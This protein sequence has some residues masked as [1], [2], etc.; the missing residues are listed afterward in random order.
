M[1]AIL[2]T[3]YYGTVFAFFCGKKNR[4]QNFDMRKAL[5]TRLRLILCGIL[6]PGGA[7]IAADFHPLD[8]IR[9]AANDFATQRIVSPGNST[10]EAGHLDPRLR[11]KRCDQP[12]S[13]EPLSRHRNNTS[14]TVIV[15]CEGAK[16]WT[17]YVPVRIKTYLTVAVATRPLARGIP[18]TAE[19]ISFEQ[20]EIGRLTSGYFETGKRL[21]GRAPKRSLPRGAVISPREL[22]IQ[23]VIRKGS[24]ISIVA[25]TN[26]VSVRMPG[27]ALE[28]AGEGE[29]I[30]VENLSSRRTITGTVLGPETVKV[31]M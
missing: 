4:H 1:V 20:R 22:D 15:R 23:K 25:E 19:D 21:L 2:S 18:V 5:I 24:R 28:D 12:L 14:M 29:Q 26:G 13:T 9:R 6:L 8:D 11:L 16:P 10:I 17:V 27:K 3:F 31:A 7:V 30:Q